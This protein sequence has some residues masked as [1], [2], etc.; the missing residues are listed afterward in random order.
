M[1]ITRRTLRLARELRVTVGAE[2]DAATRALTISWLRAWDELSAAWQ[3]AIADL[4]DQAVTLGHWPRPTDLARLARLM[5]VLA[6]TEEA[7]AALGQRTGVVVTDGAGQIIQAD[8][9]T[10]AQIIASQAP[11]ELQ[12]QLAALVNSRVG[13]TALDVIVARVAGQIT[14]HTLPLSSAAVEVMRR[15][16][17]RGV[18]I[19]D[20]PRTAA[21]RMIAR[22]EGGFNGGLTRAIVIARTE[23]LD[24]YRA[25]S[26]LTHAVNRDV[27]SGWRWLATLDRR[28]CPSCWAMHGTVHPVSDPGPDDHQQ[29][30]CARI[31]T[32]TSWAELGITAPEPPSAMP[33]ARARFNQLSADDQMQIM[34]PR[35]LELLRSG[36][37]A[38]ADLAIQ[39][40]TTGWRPSIVPTPVRTLQQRSAAAS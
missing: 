12:P 23:M 15:E 8:S 25:T 3:Q 16:L 36:R 24:A 11:R 4:V 2:A 9:Q 30:R 31:P 7:L 13:P 19:G 6:R 28:T 20:N 26:R 10:E 29:G 14:S 39:R 5:A 22:V 17:I 27:V 38:W 21:R 37:I 32:L 34:G 1:A 18:A 33:D 35:R 40:Q